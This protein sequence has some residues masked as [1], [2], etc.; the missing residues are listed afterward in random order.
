MLHQSYHSQLAGWSNSN[1]NNYQ[2]IEDLLFAVGELAISICTSRKP[3]ISKDSKSDP[4]AKFLSDKHINKLWE[5][6]EKIVK[7]T[8]K[9]FSFSNELKTIIS[10]LLLGKVSNFEAIL[11]S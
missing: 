6:I 10:D 11:E 8:D 4:F 9:N 2:K 1:G 3:F 5:Q 7:R